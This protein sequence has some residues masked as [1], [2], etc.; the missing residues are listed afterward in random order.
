MPFFR[1]LFFYFVLIFLSAAAIAN[2]ETVWIPQDELMQSIVK[3]N[4]ESLNDPDNLWQIIRE[5]IQLKEVNSELVRLHEK[6]FFAQQDYLL[7]V[8][9]RSRPLLFLITKEL[10]KRNMPMEIALLPIVES[11]YLAQATSPKGAKGLWQF[12]PATGQDYQL[13]QTWDYDARCDI[14]QSTEAALNFLQNLHEKFNDWSLALAAYNWGPGNLSRA[15]RKALHDGKKPTYE[16][17]HMPNE[18]RHYVP[19]LLAI[20]NILLA[21]PKYGLKLDKLPNKP[22]IVSVPLEQAMDIEVAAQLAEMPLQEFK[23]LNSSYLLPVFLP[24]KDRQITL[25]ADRLAIFS[26]NLKNWGNQSLTKWKPYIPTSDL[27]AE[28]LAKSFGMDKDE[29]IRL[30]HL[31]NSSIV[32]GKPILV[33]NVKQKTIAI[34]EKNV[35]QN[36]A[37]IIAVSNKNPSEETANIIEA[38]DHYTIPAAQSSDKNIASI[39]APILPRVAKM[40]V[41]HVKQGDT[42]TY[43]AK[44]YR[45]SVEHLRVINQLLSNKIKIGQT[46]KIDPVLLDDTESTGDK[47]LTTQQDIYYV[48]KKGDTLYGVAHSFG[49]HQNSI[50]VTGNNSNKLIPGQKLVIHRNK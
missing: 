9:D 11:A 5:D 8:F 35:T 4:T 37:P 32:A 17:L 10:K 45:V 19:K 21:A 7:R 23:A 43:I 39:S 28:L 14:T 41:H 12:M 13:T 18:T 33:A 47:I 34:P 25:N 22:L 49:V 1:S 27:N 6:Q 2:N 20:R 36:T 3:L 40:Q 24:N 38:V 48:I 46:L 44:I 26:N 30:N 29:L 15:I 31:K 50:T 42:L 16:N